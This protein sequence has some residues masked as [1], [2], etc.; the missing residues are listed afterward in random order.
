M[1]ELSCRV[2]G[3][4]NHLYLTKI[5]NSSWQSVQQTQFF[6]IMQDS[7][8]QSVKGL[9][10][11]ESQGFSTPLTPSV[12]SPSS[13][14][15]GTKS[16]GNFWASRR[17]NAS[18][19]SVDAFQHETPNVPEEITGFHLLQHGIGTVDSDIVAVHGLEGDPHTTW[20]HYN[21][22]LWLRDSLPHGLPHSRIMT[23]GYDAAIFIRSVADVQTTARALLSELNTWRAENIGRPIIFIC[24]SLGGI[25]VKDAL[26]IAHA[27]LSDDIYRDILY[28]TQA[29]AFL[30]TPHMGASAAWWASNASSLVSGLSGKLIPRRDA[31][32]K[33]LEK[34]SRELARISADFKKRAE[35]LII[36][37]FYETR[38]TGKAGL[39]NLVSVMLSS[40][41]QII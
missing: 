19:S 10:D 23:F 11:D 1:L 30:G 7:Y 14:W 27:T 8:D 16:L 9:L 22:H 15:L 25:I 28:S 37:S 39:S 35:R 13:S 17:R 29:V 26:N 5:H 41:Q 20:T 40:L 36:K 31:F 34:N 21:G 12:T 3:L 24:H 2:D 32:V 33:C 38:A 18:V 4:R 6:N